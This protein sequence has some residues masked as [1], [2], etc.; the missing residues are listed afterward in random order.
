MN[1]SMNSRRGGFTLVEL[2]IAL[3]LS[4]VVGAAVTGV[5]VSQSRFYDEQEKI[6][7]ARAV[8]RA[9]TN[10]LLTE[11]RAVEAQNG[12]ILA[13]A[14]SIVVR[15]PYALGVACGT[16]LTQLHVSLLPVDSALF[17][18]ARFAGYLWRDTTA[19]NYTLVENA[20][21]TIDNSP[22]SNTCAAQGVSVINT[23]GQRGRVVAVSRPLVGSTPPVTSAIMLYQRVTYRFAPS[24]MV[25]GTRGLYRQVAGSALG[26]EELAAPF[27]ASARFRFYVLNGANAQ[28][29]PPASLANLRG[30]ELVLDG[31]NE[32]PDPDGGSRTAPLTTAVFFRNR[33]D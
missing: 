14:D 4:A 21:I 7:A 22:A 16:N 8:S 24:T 2:M 28:D 26:R 15:V 1:T 9:A 12:V 19:T 30:L 31:L 3:V 10:M 6:T 27:A 11:L 23:N 13:A 17:Q 33:T 18:Q 29:A 32:R 25:P 20:L 5:F